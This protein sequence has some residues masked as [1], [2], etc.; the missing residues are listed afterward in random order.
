M[1]IPGGPEG[2]SPGPGCVPGG[3]RGVRG[4]GQR[5][6]VVLALPAAAVHQ[7][8]RVRTVLLFSFW[9]DGVYS[10]YVFLMLGSFV[11]KQWSDSF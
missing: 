9:R 5:G 3:Q 10:G 2:A 1:G 11:G 4:S 6:P 8:R 7:R